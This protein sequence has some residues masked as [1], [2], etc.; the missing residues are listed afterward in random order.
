MQWQWPLGEATDAVADGSAPGLR[1]DNGRGRGGGGSSSTQHPALSIQ[2][3]ALS[4][5]GGGLISRQAHAR[6]RPLRG[7]GVARVNHDRL[8]A[9]PGR[10]GGCGAVA[11]VPAQ[12]P[13]A[14]RRRLA[15]G[16]WR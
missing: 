6:P 13:I 14:R 1:R 11:A 5:A 4:S 10:R 8:R 15:A 7:A 16:G 12:Q 3:S 2:H 9:S